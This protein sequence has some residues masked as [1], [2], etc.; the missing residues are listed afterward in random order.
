VKPEELAQNPFFVL[1]IAPSTPRMETERAAQKLL[2]QL[3]IGA[4]SAQSYASPFGPLPRDEQLVRAALAALRDP[5]QR[6][7]Y[8]LWAGDPTSAGDVQRAFA[9]PDAFRSIGWRARCTE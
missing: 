2:A 1:G 9:W 3:A 5:E 4:A 8:E 7:L 6:A